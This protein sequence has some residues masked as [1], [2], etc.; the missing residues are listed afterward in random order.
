VGGPARRRGRKNTSR[1]FLSLSFRQSAGSGR[2]FLVPTNFAIARARSPLT[3]NPASFK[4]RHPTDNNGA[5]R[6][7]NRLVHCRC[8]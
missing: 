1:T 7:A 3:S 2:N 6:P 4:A 5:R 8:A